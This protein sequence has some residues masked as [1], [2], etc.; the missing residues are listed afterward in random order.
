MRD[1]AIASAPDLLQRHL[2][3][4]IATTWAV[5]ENGHGP[6]CRD[7]VLVVS[8]MV[9]EA[10]LDQLLHG[11]NL[12]PNA[13]TWVRIESVRRRFRAG[14]VPLSLLDKATQAFKVPGELLR[15]QRQSSQALRDDA[16]HG[17]R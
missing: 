13:L 3:A 2:D 10:L 4:Q 8:W 17:R 11:A 9:I 14:R 7:L 16:L 12:T 5:V 15:L 1:L 6:S